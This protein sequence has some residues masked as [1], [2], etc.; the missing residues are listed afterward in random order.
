MFIGTREKCALPQ[1]SHPGVAICM[2]VQWQGVRTVLVRRT[3][4]VS[5]A[6]KMLCNLSA[7]RFVLF[8]YQWK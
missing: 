8:C 6:S 4:T 5:T 2:D 1:G 3:S 7:A